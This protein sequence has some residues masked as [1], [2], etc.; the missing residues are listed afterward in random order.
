[1][2]QITS[3][4]ITMSDATEI[5]FV[6]E[7]KCKQVAEVTVTMSSGTTT[8]FRPAPTPRDKPPGPH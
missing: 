1:M 7:G 2:K 8:T 6:P 4:V 3:V 5:K